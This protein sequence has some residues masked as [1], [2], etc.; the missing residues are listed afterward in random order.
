MRLSSR[1]LIFLILPASVHAADW[2]GW[3]GPRGDG[4]SHESGFPTRWSPTSKHITWKTVIPGTGHSSPI[5]WGDRLFLTSCIEAKQQRILLCLDRGTGNI[6]WQ[7][8]VATTPLERK[9]R[10][11]SYAS[12]TPATDGRHVWVSFFAKPNML[13]ACYDFA[14]KQV[15]QTAPGEFHSRHGFCS[16]PIL[17]KNL[18]ILNGDQDALAYL[19][20]LDKTTGNEVWR[21]DRPNRTRSY[22]PPL[23]VDIAGKTQMVLSGSK[24][25]ASYNPDTGERYW[26]VDGP[27]D[28]FVASLVHQDGVLFLTGG[29]P[30]L[31]LM[32]IKPD[33][34]GNVTKTH[35]LWHE[36]RGASYVPSPIAYGNCFFV[37]SD[38]GLASC[39]DVPTGKRHWFERLGSRHSASPVATADGI[40]YFNDDDGIT[41][42]LRAGPEF[43]LLHTNRLGEATYASPALSEGQIFLRGEHHLY[44]IGKRKQP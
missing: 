41:Y 22:C 30:T 29:Y 2:P 28:Q 36:R 10:L 39:L 27:T 9:H 43:E 18:V 25:V 37:V 4:T 20:A 24:C 8:V 6:L 40:L 1:L 33:G 11:N 26:I 5:V 16:P 7:R 32:A 14:G 21:I 44:C 13:V 15:W 23:I 12:S 19:V 31:H 42:V 34:L 17:Y 35:V 3:R 38:K